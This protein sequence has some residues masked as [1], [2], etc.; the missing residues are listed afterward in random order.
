MIATASYH[1]VGRLEETLGETE[2]EQLDE[3]ILVKRAVISVEGILEV[4]RDELSDGH[5][6]RH[7]EG[8]CLS[9]RVGGG[10]PRHVH[11][12]VRVVVAVDVELRVGITLAADINVADRGIEKP[13]PQ[14]MCAHEIP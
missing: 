4:I 10:L 5:M 14:N 12:P 7:P 9:S 6:F 13:K 8:S 3:H 1:A 11:G 2:I